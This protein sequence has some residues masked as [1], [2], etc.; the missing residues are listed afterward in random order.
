MEHN[1][2]IEIE[3]GRRSGQPCVRGTRITVGDVLECLASGMSLQEIL[4]D[5]PDLTEENV[6]A[7]LAYA[8]EMARRPMAKSA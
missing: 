6:R 7:C 8:A 5:F 2:H 1:A 3:P 4:H